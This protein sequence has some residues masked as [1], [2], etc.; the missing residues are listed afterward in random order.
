MI[1]NLDLMD[2]PSSQQVGDGLSKK[3]RDPFQ[4]LLSRSVRQNQKNMRTM[5]P[6]KFQNRT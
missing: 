2:N 1:E 5:E 4:Y 6:Q 3:K